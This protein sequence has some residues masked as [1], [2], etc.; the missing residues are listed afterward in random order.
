MKHAWEHDFYWLS[1]WLVKVMQTVRGKW[2]WRKEDYVHFW[3]YIH[4]YQIKNAIK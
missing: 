3:K 4:E 2:D 1:A